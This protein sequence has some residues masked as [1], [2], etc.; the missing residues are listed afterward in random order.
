MASSNSE[1]TTQKAQVVG[2]KDSFL[3]LLFTISGYVAVSVLTWALSALPMVNL[4]PKW[5]FIKVPLALLIG[6]ALK[7]LDR[8][9]HE[10]PA[11][12]QTG[13]VQI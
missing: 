11:D 2:V 12:P 8:F 5:E 3:M 13:L 6:A 4:G 10:N 9:K 1:V 7:G